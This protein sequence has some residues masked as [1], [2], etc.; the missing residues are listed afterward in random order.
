MRSIRLRGPRDGRCQICQKVAELPIGTLQCDSCKQEY[1]EGVCAKCANKPC[2]SCKGRLRKPEDVFPASLFRAVHDGDDRTV[3]ALL[4]KHRVDPNT[5]THPNGQTLLSIA[6][7]AKDPEGAEAVSQ[8]LIQMGMS[9]H[10]RDKRT[11]RTPLIDAVIY[12]K[13]RR[14]VVE[15]LRTSVNDQ[16]DFGKTALMYA[17]EGA[18]FFGNPK[19][20]VAIATTLVDLGADALVKDQAGRTA[21]AH[22]LKSDKD[23]KNQNM[24]DFLK[25]EML[26]QTAEREFRARFTYTFDKAGDLKIASRSAFGSSSKAQRGA[27]KVGKRR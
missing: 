26:R 27:S 4:D 14:A 2:R 3:S 25:R 23:S 19:G 22:A 10:C 7:C 17:S 9:I 8:R 5:L 18:G 1:L 6:V 12:R 21:L 11:G 20:S 15:P 16:D 24:V 13:V